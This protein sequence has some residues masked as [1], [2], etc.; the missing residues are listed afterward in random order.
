ME[1]KTIWNEALRTGLVLGGISIAYTVINIL[2]SKIQGGTAVSVLV[3]VS[4][5]LLWVF[6]LVLCIKLFKVFML[7]FSAAHE[8]LTNSESFRY[9]VAMA[10]LSALLYSAFYLAWITLIQPDMI[11]DSMELASEAYANIFTAE[12]LESMEELTP[13][14]PALTF[15]GNLLYCTLFGTVLSAIF[16]RNIPSRN[17]FSDNQ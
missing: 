9:G 13:K 4:G 12:Q 3:N 17:P 16:S 6:K 7:K 2:L 8:D 5:V 11:K 1:R 10:F 14:L 15:F